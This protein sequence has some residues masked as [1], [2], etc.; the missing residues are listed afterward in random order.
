ML[1][2]QLCDEIVGKYK[3]CCRKCQNVTS[4]GARSEKKP[5]Q[6]LQLEHTWQI[7]RTEKVEE[8]RKS[9]RKKKKTIPRKIFLK[10]SFLTNHHPPNKRN[11]VC[12]RLHR[13]KTLQRKITLYSYFL[14]PLALRHI[15][16]SS[17]F[18]CFLPTNPTLFYG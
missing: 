6:I 1:T 5:A 4:Y 10:N 11:L 3:L 2:M 16:A 7:S 8:K 13:V 9:W 17:T 18:L 15:S 12:G 14:D